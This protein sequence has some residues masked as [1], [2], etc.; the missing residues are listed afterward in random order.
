MEQY[1]YESEDIL[2]RASDAGTSA[3][4]A[5]AAQEEEASNT[6]AS[7]SSIKEESDH[8]YPRLTINTRRRLIR[9]PLPKPPGQKET[10]KGAGPQSNKSSAPASSSS[11][12]RSDSIQEATHHDSHQVRSAGLTHSA[13]FARNNLQKQHT[14]TLEEA[15]S[16]ARE[17]VAKEKAI[18]EWWP[19]I[20]HT[21]KAE[22]A[23]ETSSNDREGQYTLNARCRLHLERIVEFSIFTNSDLSKA[24][25]AGIARGII[26]AIVQC[27]NTLTK[28]EALAA[29]QQT[30]SVMWRVDALVRS[31]EQLSGARGGLSALL[32]I[33]GV[34]WSKLASWRGKET[35]E[36]PIDGLG[37]SRTLMPALDRRT[38]SSS[39]SITLGTEQRRRKRDVAMQL[40]N[41]A[42]WTAGVNV[43]GE[44]VLAKE[45]DEK[46]IH[47][48]KKRPAGMAPSLLS[49]PMAPTVAL[50]GELASLDAEVQAS[51]KDNAKEQDKSE[52]LPVP[53]PMAERPSMLTDRLAM[54]LRNSAKLQAEGS[55]E[56]AARAGTLPARNPLS[57][58]VS[59]ASILDKNNQPSNNADAAKVKIAVCKVCVRF[60]EE[61]NRATAKQI[62]ARRKS[63]TLTLKDVRRRLENVSSMSGRSDKTI[64]HL[65]S[66]QQQS[67]QKDSVAIDWLPDKFEGEPLH[68]NPL[69]SDV[70]GR[71]ADDANDGIKIIGGSFVVYGVE[72]KL[73]IV[74]HNTIDIALYAAIA[75]VLETAFLMDFDLDPKGDIEV[76]SA[77]E[78]QQSQPEVRFAEETSQTE[79]DQESHLEKN[80]VNPKPDTPEQSE[81]DKN[82]GQ[83]R[84]SIWSMLH[85]GSSSAVVPATQTPDTKAKRSSVIFPRTKTA[86]ANLQSRPEKDAVAGQY[87]RLGRIL[88]SFTGHSEKKSPTGHNDKARIRS[89][90]DA[91]QSNLAQL[92]EDE[93]TI[94]AV[95]TNPDQQTS[96]LDGKP[97]KYISAYRE[98]EPLEEEEQDIN[99]DLIEELVSRQTLS[100]LILEGLDISLPFAR[101]VSTNANSKG[102]STTAPANPTTEAKKGS[103]LSVH[104]STQSRISSFSRATDSTA[105]SNQDTSLSGRAQRVEN[106]AEQQFNFEKQRREVLFYQRGGNCRDASLGQAIEEMTAK[107]IV[108]HNEWLQTEKSSKREKEKQLSQTNSPTF[109]I[110]QYLHG[111]DKI[112]VSA[113]IIKS[114]TPASAK[115][116]SN[117]TEAPTPNAADAKEVASALKTDKDLAQTALRL[118]EHIQSAA[119][120]QP[121]DNG[122]TLK[123]P[124]KASIEMWH[125]DMR[126]GR[127][128]AV[129]SMSDATYLASYG[130]FLNDLMTSHFFTQESPLLLAPGGD[131]AELLD[132]SDDP[133]RDLVRLFKI[134]NVIL[135]FHVQTIPIHHLL[136]DGPVVCLEDL[137]DDEGEDKA[138]KKEKDHNTLTKSL[139]KETRLEVQAFFASVKEE[140]SRMEQMF[141]ARELDVNGNTVKP[142]A[143][144]S[145]GHGSIR[146]VFTLDTATEEQQSD[147]NSIAESTTSSY[148]GAATG[149]LELLGKV[150][151]SM[152]KAEFRLY[153]SLKEADVS[154]L[155]DVRRQFLD[156]ARSCRNRLVAW[157]KKHL[158]KSELEQ[159][160]A[161]KFAEPYYFEK[162]NHALP[163]SRFVLRQEEPLSIIAYSLS[164]R[165]FN[166]EI[167]ATKSSQKKHS[168]V[169]NWRSSVAIGEGREDA[170]SLLSSS[171]A[172]SSAASVTSS[173]ATDELDP[174]Q[175]DDFHVPEPLQVNMKRKRRTKDTGILSIRIRSSVY[176]NAQ[177]DV[178]QDAG[179]ESVDHSTGE[180]ILSANDNSSTPTASRIGSAAYT[181]SSTHFDT[182]TSNNETF[183]AHVSTISPR[184]ALGDL[185]TQEGDHFGDLAPPSDDGHEAASLLSS[186]VSSTSSG[187]V[188]RKDVRETPKIHID[189][190]TDAS[191]DGEKSADLEKLSKEIEDVDTS[192]KGSVKKAQVESTPRIA[193]PLNKSPASPHI[194]H[195]II[196][197][198][199]K[200]SCVSWFAEDFYKLRKT[201][202]I[203]DDFIASLSRSKSWNNVGGKSKS[204]F[205]L[206]G[207]GKWI[208][209][210]LLNVWTV[211]EKEA[212]LEFAPA[213][214][215]Y[216]MNS[217]V[218]D[219]PTLLVKIAGV[220]S[221]KIKDIKTGE[222][223]LKLSVQVLENVFAGDGGRSIRF[224][225]KGIRDRRAQQKVQN[226][227][228]A[229]QQQEGKPQV[230]SKEVDEEDVSNA[231][232]WWDGEWIDTM[233]PRAFVPEQQKTQ[234]QRALRNDLAFLTASNVMD[235]SLL[236]GVNEPICTSFSKEG[237]KSST[238][239]HPFFRVRI[240]DFLGA[241]TLV[242]Q[243]ESSGKKAIKSQ[244]PTVIPPQDYASRFSQA[245]EG[246]F[247]GCP[248]TTN[249]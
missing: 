15:R 25:S 171:V 84:K 88:S 9:K 13:I 63:E 181:P 87:S 90:S 216:M 101:Q 26:D 111:R 231:S 113:A 99:E 85:M 136:I 224:D 182:V 60:E 27:L 229:P 12:S 192:T 38:A 4:A 89:F 151:S 3:A 133:K 105:Q 102:T 29:L 70:E 157:S 79:E 21:I 211:D 158:N 141:V 236:V 41:N 139:V 140:I 159:L 130:T 154:A 54:Q 106:R 68:L 71:D 123:P 176:S 203:E 67:A 36:L 213:Y 186:S 77:T 51:Q 69:S 145:S 201:W 165:D 202:K 74:I 80:G 10:R 194:K 155:N 98:E 96:L 187:T 239:K 189:A 208:A 232:V 160:G 100:V 97:P 128:T 18:L 37:G 56:H 76:D 116:S 62:R 180:S 58:T 200:I 193:P 161:L 131:D 149:P 33:L 244:T 146:S 164:S 73:R 227:E 65:L 225:L 118:A 107:A 184:G 52:K 195:T 247:I 126:T 228:S 243:L 138:T 245:I 7:Q 117:V 59:H 196:S 137:N 50:T 104:P 108:L 205:Y 125:A 46:V 40:L 235:Y 234:F 248:D 153:E 127:Q 48:E 188:N 49:K 57:R 45:H 82:Q 22:T 92:L 43:E 5:A 163:G 86:D 119:Q 238:D 237:L 175:D 162:G 217:A 144:S 190:Q 185:F 11:G 93:S 199:L 207:D 170:S 129:K 16:R 197:G 169:L 174:D 132:A 103:T 152:R 34:R 178:E 242:K 241:W 64:G 1:D 8:S 44:E 32:G 23:Q 19:D 206:T 78:G 35:G 233:L 156:R 124:H 221:L 17:F 191:H 177:K 230:A 66:E 2:R 42:F 20:N 30:S 135:K 134:D 148:A 249:T 120:H 204:G 121:I 212:F 172:S 209:K 198:D 47:E 91:K 168:D 222:V 122:S 214:L 179:L 166:E 240:V 28:S 219:C 210:Q 94:E 183:H 39:S 143:P 72:E 24:E 14:L 215:R 83:W 167:H 95:E 6:S 75:M 53:T 147:R 142:P 226:S 109:K 112:T 55:V 31:N 223:K 150:M 173:K 81:S 220:Y 61:W 115:M 114:T 218:N 246:Y 110:A